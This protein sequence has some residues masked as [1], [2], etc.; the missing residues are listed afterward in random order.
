[1][2]FQ[3]EGLSLLYELPHAIAV[4]G[5][6]FVIPYSQLR[7]LVRKDSPLYYLVAG[8]GKK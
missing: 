7:P 1:M 5:E 4:C 8:D 2:F 6:G 3:T